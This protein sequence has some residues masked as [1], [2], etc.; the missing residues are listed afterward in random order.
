MSVVSWVVLGFLAGTI[1]NVLTD[2]RSGL[3]CLTRIAVGVIGAFVGGALVRAA[4]GRAVTGFGLRSVR[5]AARG[6][7]AFLFVLS[8][9]EVRRGG[10]PPSVRPGP[11]RGRVRNGPPM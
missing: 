6:A 8:A 4:G 11:P 1:A 2:R 10:P 7:T 3:G 5:V 9:I